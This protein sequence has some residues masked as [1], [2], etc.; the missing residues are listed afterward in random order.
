MVGRECKSPDCSLSYFKIRDGRDE[1]DESGEKTLRT[2]PYCG[3][4]DACEEFFTAAQL[5]W[6]ERL[7]HRDIE[8]TIVRQLNRSFGRMNRSQRGPLKMTA[9]VTVS[10]LPSAAPYVE[11][12]L[13]QATTCD[14]CGGAYAVYGISYY[15]PFCAGGT[16]GAHIRQSCEAARTLAAIADTTGDKH[17]QTVR[18]QLLGN[19]Y[20]DA[21]TLFE[22]FLRRLYEYGLKTRRNAADVSSL[23]GK[24]RN[25]FQRLDDADAIIQRDLGLD[26]FCELMVADRERLSAVFC[27]RHILTHNLGLVWPAPQTLIQVL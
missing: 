9:K 25:S 1:G 14:H 27:K 26:L 10:V 24:L 20:E 6:I 7:L 15:C 16:L 3:H 13:K 4:Q 2:C 22:G 5:D 23:V 17:W 8:Q 12:K 21:V 18:D 11:E 19:A